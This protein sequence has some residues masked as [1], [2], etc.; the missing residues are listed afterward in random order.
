VSS[1]QELQIE[2]VH[3]NVPAKL[4]EGVAISVFRVL[5]EALSNAGKH[6]GARHCTVTLQG[7]ADALKLEVIDDGHGF[8]AAAMRKKRGLGLISMEERLKL[9]NGELV[10]ES[11]VGAGTAVRG[12]VP[13][14]LHPQMDA[15]TVSPSAGRAVSSSIV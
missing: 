14:S 10:V 4:P 8:D 2:Y 7:S 11:N 1:H 5:Q 15:Q 3:N 9:V 12:S 6:S 13:L